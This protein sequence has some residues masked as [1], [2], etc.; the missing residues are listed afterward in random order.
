MQATDKQFLEDSY[1][2][3]GIL[4]LVIGADQERKDRPGS[5]ALKKAVTPAALSSALGLIQVALLNDDN[6]MSLLMCSLANNETAVVP[7]A[8]RRSG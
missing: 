2:R 8:F 3:S 5:L 7:H 1:A 4:S 6:P